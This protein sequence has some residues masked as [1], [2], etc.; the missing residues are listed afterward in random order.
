MPSPSRLLLFSLVSAS[1]CSSYPAA[2]LTYLPGRR[3]VDLDRPVMATEFHAGR[4]VLRVDSEAVVDGVAGY[5]LAIEVAATD[6]ASQP[7]FEHVYSLP[8]PDVKVFLVV[9]GDAGRPFWSRAAQGQVRV[10]ELDGSVVLSCDLVFEGA[11]IDPKLR[12][13]VRVAKDDARHL[14]FA[15]AFEADR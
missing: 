8:S 4:R 3:I 7:I 13:P 9:A 11:A 15:G 14:Y 10:R 2:S 6:A 1:A 12:L 5:S